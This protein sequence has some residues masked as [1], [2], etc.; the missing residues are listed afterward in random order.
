MAAGLPHLPFPSQVGPQNGED[1]DNLAS[2]MP[3][4][5]QKFMESDDGESSIDFEE[6]HRILCKETSEE[7]L[8][9]GIASKRA[10][11]VLGR[12]S[13]TQTNQ[14]FLSISPKVKGSS[15][16]GGILRSKDSSPL[17]SLKHFDGKEN[18]PLQGNTRPKRARIRREGSGRAISHRPL[19]IDLRSFGAILNEDA[20]KE[21]EILEGV[22]AFWASEKDREASKSITCKLRGETQAHDV[23][24][25]RP[26][27]SGSVQTHRTR[28][29][30]KGSGRQLMSKTLSV[31][32]PG[33]T[34]CV[35]SWDDEQLEEEEE[36]RPT[37]S[38]M[39]VD[40]SECEEGI[41]ISQDDNLPGHV[42]HIEGLEVRP[43]NEVPGFL[44]EGVDTLQ[45]PVTTE[46]AG[47]GSPSKSQQKFVEDGALEVIIGDASKSTPSVNDVPGHVCAKLSPMTLPTPP[48]NPLAALGLSKEKLNDYIGKRKLDFES[49][50]DCSSVPKTV[51]I[52]IDS[53]TGVKRSTHP[54]TLSGD[55]VETVKKQDIHVPYTEVS[56]CAQP[57][58]AN[59]ELFEEGFLNK[60]SSPEFGAS[61]L[62][63]T[64]VIATNQ[65]KRQ[66]ICCVSAEFMED[67]AS[68][69]GGDVPSS[70][71]LREPTIVN[72]AKRQGTGVNKAKGGPVAKKCKKFRNSLAGFGVRWDGDV[73][74]ST[75]IKS[76][77]LEYWRGLVTVIGIKYSSPPACYPKRG[78]KGPNFKV[79]SFVSK[80]YSDYVRFAAL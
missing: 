50:L 58:C 42:S 73:R 7:F 29:R 53:H 27:I 37:K 19:K 56:M 40:F 33:H 57:D 8:Q 41:N 72:A 51:A 5:F 75:R 62:D 69:C 63:Q 1:E 76:R 30:R 18:V 24:N 64:L 55:A 67:K 4:F 79:E 34:E 36:E 52:G 28:I 25:Q 26:A 21:S 77:P 74:R 32:L 23:F 59:Q 13:E 14:H 45:N 49:N 3:N 12:S 43:P 39:L 70:L 6:V 38:F 65:D 60:E 66:E 22:Y 35:R 46:L 61:Q 48:S 78:Y 20:P 44:A 16:I 80:E 10:L 31:E 9:T 15:D 47:G 68:S 17:L 2:L 54:V 11:P 71:C